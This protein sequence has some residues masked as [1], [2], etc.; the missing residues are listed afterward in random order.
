[1]AE[2]FDLIVYLLLIGAAIGG[3]RKG[4]LREVLIFIVWIPAVYAIVSIMINNF[5]PTEGL[6][7]QSQASLKYIGMMFL[8]ASI[9]VVIADYAFIKPTLRDVADGSLLMANKVAGLAFGTARVFG[10]IIIGMAMFDIYARPLDD[11]KIVNDSA[12]LSTGKHMAK[13]FVAYLRDNNYITNEVTMY[14]YAEEQERKIR[15]QYDDIMPTGNAGIFNL[16]KH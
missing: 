4:L 3:W 13:D 12:V 7:S 15:E 11:V 6:D 10:L 14:D 1:M 9:V 8:G 5:T 2:K 16:G